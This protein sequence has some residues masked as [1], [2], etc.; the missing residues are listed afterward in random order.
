MQHINPEKVFGPPPRTVDLEAVFPAPEVPTGTQRPFR[1]ASIGWAQ[2][3]A[4]AQDIAYYESR[5]NYKPM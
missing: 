5:R 3:R 2:D 4:T 1:K